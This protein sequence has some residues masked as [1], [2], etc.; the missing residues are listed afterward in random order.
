MLA[1]FSL[2]CKL[3]KNIV[4]PPTY[5]LLQRLVELP[6]LYVRLAVGIRCPVINTSFVVSLVPTMALPG[7]LEIC[8]TVV[9]VVI[10][11]TSITS[12]TAGASVKVRMLPPAPV[13]A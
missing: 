5:R 11:R 9:V 7:L 2:S 1:G 8:V 3:P 13:T 4:L 6:K 12:D 10:S